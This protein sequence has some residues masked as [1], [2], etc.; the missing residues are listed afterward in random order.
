MGHITWSGCVLDSAFEIFHYEDL[1]GSRA[2]AN[3]QSCAPRSPRTASCSFAA[4][5]SKSC[6]IQKGPPQPCSR[7]WEELFISSLQTR[8]LRCCICKRAAR[9]QGN[10][11]GASPISR[12]V[13]ILAFFS[14]SVH[15][16]V[17]LNA[18]CKHHSPLIFGEDEEFSVLLQ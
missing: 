3:H 17:S 5:R 9:P 16:S 4:G 11:N 8:L 18:Q 13:F 7:L 14:S 12:L 15:M 10:P 6:R 2:W 1:P